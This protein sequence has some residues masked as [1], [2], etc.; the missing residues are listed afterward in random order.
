MA[1]IARWLGMRCHSVTDDVAESVHTAPYLSPWATYLVEAPLLADENR[2]ALLQLVLQVLAWRQGRG[3]A[4][5][6]K[7]FAGAAKDWSPRCSKARQWL[8]AKLYIHAFARTGNVRLP[9][10]CGHSPRPVACADPPLVHR[11]STRSLQSLQ[12]P[13]RGKRAQCAR[14][15]GCR[16]GWQSTRRCSRFVP[17]LSPT[18]IRM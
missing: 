11:L 17:W 15:Q 1:W 3:G 5:I 2:R 13:L 8:Y 18:P 14:R 12:L 4:W 7:L 9:L 16:D 10:P 6:S